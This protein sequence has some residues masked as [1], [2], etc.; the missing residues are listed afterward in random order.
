[1]TNYE[2]VLLELVKP[3]TSDPDSVVV[4]RMGSLE[5]NEIVLYVYA[6]KEDL[7]RLIGRKGSM[8]Q[9]IRTLLQSVC[10]GKKRIVVKFEEI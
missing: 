5:E 3:L 9:S 1:M 8:A 4:K 7:A 2:E 10:H 6:P